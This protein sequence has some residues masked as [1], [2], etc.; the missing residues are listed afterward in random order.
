MYNDLNEN[1]TAELC[2]VDWWNFTNPDDD[3]AVNAIQEACDTQ[4]SRSNTEPTRTTDHIDN[5]GS[6][7]KKGENI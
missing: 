7:P 4:H 2:G 6:G 5:L 1:S 3:K